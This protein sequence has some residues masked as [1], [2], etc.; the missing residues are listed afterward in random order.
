MRAKSSGALEQRPAAKP[1]KPEG[2]RLLLAE[3]RQ[4]ILQARA[5]VA[6]AV[7]SGLVALYWNIG[8]RI[9]QTS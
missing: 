3:V 5:G 4:M 1:A 8:R 6:R 2:G 7:E 9:R